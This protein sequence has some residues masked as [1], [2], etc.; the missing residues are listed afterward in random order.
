VH[1]LDQ[2]TSGIMLA[3][4]KAD[5]HK[6]LQKQF[7]QRSINKRYVAVLSKRIGKKVINISLP[8]RVDLNDRPRQL[9]CF[10]YGKCAETLVELI[11]HEKEYSRV[12]FYPKTGRTHQLRVHAA[13]AEGLN[14]PI[15]GDQLYG[16]KDKRLMLHAESIE[17][18]HPV[19]KQRMTFKI[20][21]PF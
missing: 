3:A 16:S 18:E 4:K 7:I 21:A 2:A 1:R 17:F 10:E 11:R 13:H 12:Y 15:V 14:S 5:V 20:D 19:L 9:V 6:A 8:L